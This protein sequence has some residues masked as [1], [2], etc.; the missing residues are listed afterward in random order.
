MAG[1]GEQEMDRGMQGEKQ[2][3]TKVTRGI[4]VMSK[5]SKRKLGYKEDKIEA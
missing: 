4:H 2:D 1:D 3:E 5:E